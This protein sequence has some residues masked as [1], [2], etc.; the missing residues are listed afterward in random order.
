[1]LSGVHTLILRG[2]EQITDVSNLGEVH[3]LDLT[4]CTGV[5][6]F[7]MLGKDGQILIR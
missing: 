5:T 6:D 1:M 4:G 7:S 3:I 2:C